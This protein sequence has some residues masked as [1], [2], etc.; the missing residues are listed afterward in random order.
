VRAFADAVLPYPTLGEVG[1]RAAMSY[2][3]PAA[4]NPWVRGIIALLRQ[5]G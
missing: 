4:A 5:F 1:K 3:A 2:F